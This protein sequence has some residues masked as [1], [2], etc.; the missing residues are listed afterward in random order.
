MSSARWQV[1]VQSVGSELDGVT[2]VGDPSTPASAPALCLNF[3]EDQ[4]TEVGDLV[5]SGSLLLWDRPRAA[6]FEEA[7]ERFS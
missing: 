5:F 6:T 3:P 2:E 4:G 1:A 7:V